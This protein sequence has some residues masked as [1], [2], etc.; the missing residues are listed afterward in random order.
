[1]T[2]GHLG[3]RRPR[4]A[5]RAVAVVP[6]VERVAQIARRDAAEQHPLQRVRERADGELGDEPHRDRA[7]G[8]GARRRSGAPPDRGAARRSGARPPRA[9]RCPSHS[10]MCV[11]A[12]PAPPPASASHSWNS[13][14]VSTGTGSGIGSPASAGTPRVSLAARYF[15]GSDSRGRRPAAERRGEVDD[16]RQELALEGQRRLQVGPRVPDDLPSLPGRIRA[17]FLGKAPESSHTAW[18]SLAV[19]QPGSWYN[20]RHD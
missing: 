17:D 11:A 14:G 18:G 9:G 5:R 10:R 3:D 19:Y 8:R 2:A 1:M 16:A 15:G 4:S 7:T 13:V 6:R 12:S 20:E